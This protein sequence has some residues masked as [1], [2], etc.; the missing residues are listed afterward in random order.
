VIVGAAVVPST[1]LL[2]PDVSLTTPQ[3]LEP[4]RRA[5]AA[6]LA[7]LCGAE[8]VTLLAEGTPGLHQAG[9]ASLAGIGRGDLTGAVTADESLL[10]AV[11]NATRYPILRD[12][13]LTGGLSVLA[14]LLGSATPVV[15]VTVAGTARFDE[16][17][18]VGAGIAR[19]LGRPGLRAAVVAAGDLSG[20]LGK[21]SPL[22][23]VEGAVAWDERAVAAVD[24]GRL[25]ELGR[26]GPREARRVGALGWA[27]LSVLHGVLA[28]FRV[29]MVARHYSAPLG[30]GYLVAQGG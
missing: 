15:P 12:G 10:T 14:M 21:R 27:P 9:T 30:V 4:V 18:S 23:E 19:A 3:G 22:Y 16:L 6:A 24:G 8:V 29:G 20:G 5:A 17:V 13:P 1:P 2:L 11:S 7:G 28:Q 25:D 26:L